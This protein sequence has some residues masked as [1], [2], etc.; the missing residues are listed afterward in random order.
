MKRLFDT[1]L[2]GIGLLLLAP[3][4]L[5]LAVWI[6]LD[7]RGPVFYKQVRVGRGNRDFLLYKFTMAVGADSKGLLTVATTRVSPVPDTASANTSSTSF[8]SSSTSSKA[9]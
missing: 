2:S 4:F 5:V 6:K 7:T 9:T 8:P 3:L 1:L